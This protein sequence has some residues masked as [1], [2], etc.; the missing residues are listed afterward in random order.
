[1][2]SR[3]LLSVWA[4]LFGGLLVFA[5]ISVGVLEPLSLRRVS[6]FEEIVF[7][8]IAGLPVIAW[9]VVFFRSP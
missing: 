7:L 6:Q 5:L 8:I 2:S 4:C 3:I 1:M 9:C